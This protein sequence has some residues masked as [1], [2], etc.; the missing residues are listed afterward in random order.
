MISVCLVTESVD[1]RKGGIQAWSNLIRRGFEICSPSTL[2]RVVETDVSKFYF[3]NIITSKV[4]LVMNVRCMKFM[5]PVLIPLSFF[6]RVFFVVHGDDVLSKSKMEELFLFILFYF[7]R[8]K[9]ISNSVYT[10][11]LLERKWGRSSEV[12][13]PFIEVVDIPKLKRKREDVFKIVSVGRLVLRK[14]HAGVIRAVSELNSYGDEKYQY[15]IIGSGPMLNEINT[16]IDELG[17]SEYVHVLGSLSDEEKNNEL[18]CA[19]LFAMPSLYKP[20]DATVEG[21]GMVFVEASA[22][23]VPS[24]SGDSGGMP[25]AVVPGVTGE[26]C[27]GTVE[28]I[29]NSILVVKKSEYLQ[30]ELL[31]HAYIHDF[32]KQEYFFEMMLAKQ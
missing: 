22:M 1:N 18:S 20:D 6:K 10:Q 23:G 21:Y 27:D 28:G 25:E 15:S 24:L 12:V 26:V 31:A 17:V 5:L 2:V 16:L 29:I 30:E 19:D 14:N 4:L 8:A 3:W 9:Y 7:V 13:N 32:K 11:K